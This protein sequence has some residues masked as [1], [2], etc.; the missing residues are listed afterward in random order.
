MRQSHRD[1]LTR[2]YEQ[3]G[4]DLYRYL[5]VLMGGR[6]RAEDVLQEVFLRLL[7]VAEKEP[8]ALENRAYVFRVAR[9]EA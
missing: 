6:D 4:R 3:F 8:S 9:N 2:V 5:S 7:S 1:T